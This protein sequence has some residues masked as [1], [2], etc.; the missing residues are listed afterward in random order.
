MTQRT[1]TYLA[2]YLPDDLGDSPSQDLV[3]YYLPADQ[4]HPT[5]RLRQSSHEFSL[6]KL[7]DATQEEQTITLVEDEFAALAEVEARVI[8]KTR[9]AYT[10]E[11]KIAD[12]DV[13]EGPLAGLVVVQ[14]EL[15]TDEEKQAF[16]MPDFCLADVTHE[17]F[18][19]EG[20]LA[21][22]TYREVEPHLHR[23]GYKRLV[24]S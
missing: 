20:M 13:F 6:T 12:I 2:R 4:A 24:G 8:R 22:M 21:G 7:G 14:F 16:S 10:H 23:F 11:G 5:L 3:D 1:I 17:A 18:V 9:Y 19:A 15:A